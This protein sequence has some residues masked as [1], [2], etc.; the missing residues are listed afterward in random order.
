MEDVLT[1]R[2]PL[3]YAHRV[4]QREVGTYLDL[5][6]KISN[7]STKINSFYFHLSALTTVQ[8]FDLQPQGLFPH[9]K[10]QIIQYQSTVR[11]YSIGL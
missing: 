4:Q 11:K 8:L 3:L 2:T 10:V 1:T 7:S 5:Q 9:L 6:L